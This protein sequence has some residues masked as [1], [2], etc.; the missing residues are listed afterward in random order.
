MFSG[1]DFATLT[2]FLSFSCLIFIW[3]FDVFSAWREV[4]SNFDIVLPSLSHLRII[5]L[6]STPCHLGPT[7]AL[8]HEL[9]IDLVINKQHD[10]L[11][12][13]PPHSNLH[14]GPLLFHGALLVL[15]DLNHLPPNAMY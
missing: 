4:T 13:L 3:F 2:H 6:L 9:H 11:A 8:G 14:M 15:I 10:C 12:R 1:P 7:H 5:S